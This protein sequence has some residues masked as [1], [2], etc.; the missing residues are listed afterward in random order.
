VSAIRLGR[1]IFNHVDRKAHRG[2]LRKAS[3]GGRRE[4]K[5]KLIATMSGP[6]MAL[7]GRD[8]VVQWEHR[9]LES[10]T[11]IERSI[12]ARRVVEPAHSRIRFREKSQ[13]LLSCAQI[14]RVRASSRGHAH[15]RT[16][17]SSLSHRCSFV[18]CFLIRSGRDRSC[19]LLVVAV[20]E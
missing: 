4:A 2:A 11:A 16:H 6:L 17:V 20:M 1:P 5:E 19:L 7:F 13:I 12:H 15:A 18:C 9:R 10:Q 3:K 8:D 14:S